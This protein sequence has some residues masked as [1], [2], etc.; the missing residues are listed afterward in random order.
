MLAGCGLLGSVGLLVF[1]ADEATRGPV[2]TVV[3]LLVVAAL[4]GWFAPRG[5]RKSMAASEEVAAG[6]EGSGEPTALWLLPVIVVA[7]AA[8]FALLGSWDAALRV[9]GGCTLVG[10]AQAV[11][12]ERLVA[13]DEERRR[14]VYFR[15]P[16]SRILRG[17]K[18]G[19]R[20]R[21]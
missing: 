10:L 4:L 20:P 2:S 17:T 15:R 13:A 12:I 18:L 14:R 11:L 3:Q 8:P 5:A 19:F 7:L 21:G 1:A 6:D 9:T 16:G